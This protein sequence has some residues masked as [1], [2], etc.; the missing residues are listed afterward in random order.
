MRAK[1]FAMCPPPQCVHCSRPY[2]TLHAP[3][4]GIS[5]FSLTTTGPGTCRGSGNPSGLLSPVV[6]FILHSRLAPKRDAMF[7]TILRI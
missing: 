6:L 5:L 2:S 7:L 1:D 3:R 4:A